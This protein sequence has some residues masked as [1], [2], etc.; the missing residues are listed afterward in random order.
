LTFSQPDHL[1]DDA[2]AAEV[3]IGTKRAQEGS[4]IFQSLLDGGA[5][6]A[7][8]SDWPVHLKTCFLLGLSLTGKGNIFSS[9]G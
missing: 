8:G 3:K 4:Y 5:Q 9:L 1:L 7:F 2:G 6:L